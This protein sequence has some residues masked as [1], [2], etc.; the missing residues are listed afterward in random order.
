MLS[1]M[2]RLRENVADALGD[3]AEKLRRIVGR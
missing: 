1:E 2:D 3:V